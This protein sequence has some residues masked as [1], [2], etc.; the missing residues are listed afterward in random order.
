MSP[1]KISSLPDT[2]VTFEQSVKKLL[3]LAVTFR[4]SLLVGGAILQRRLTAIQIRSSRE[5]NV[6]NNLKITTSFI[7]PTAITLPIESRI[8]R[9]ICT[10]NTLRSFAQCASVTSRGKVFGGTPKLAE[11]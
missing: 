4:K 6:L 3:Y 8:Y 10:V 7:A 5:N 2:E 9:R 11:G 1:F